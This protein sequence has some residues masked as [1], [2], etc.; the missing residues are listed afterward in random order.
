MPRDRKF[1][2]TIDPWAWLALYYA[3]DTYAQVGQSAPY[4]SNDWFKVGVSSTGYE[5]LGYLRFWGL[6][7]D[8]QGAHVAIRQ[9]ELCMRVLP[10]QEANP[11]PITAVGVAAFDYATLMYQSGAPNNGLP[12]V[13]GRV[14]ATNGNMPGQAT[15]PGWAVSPSCGGYGWTS[16]DVSNATGVRQREGMDWVAI[17]LSGNN[18]SGAGTAK[19][20]ISVEGASPG[21]AYAGTGGAPVLMLNWKWSAYQTTL[22]SPADGEQVAT[23]TPTLQAMLPNPLEPAAGGGG[24]N[25][26]GPVQIMFQVGTSPDL[27]SGGQVWSSGWL[28]APAT[29]QAKSSTMP[30]NILENGGTYYWSA[31][32]FDGEIWSVASNARKFT[33]NLQLGG[34]GPSP[35]DS[36]G[37]ATV[38]LATGNLFV[39]TQTQSFPAVGGTVGATFSYNSLAP[40]DQGLKGEYFG[41]NN[42]TNLVAER[43]TPS[44]WF[45][46][47]TGPPFENGPI[48]GW[49]ARMVR[50]RPGV[51]H[52]WR[53][54]LHHLDLPRRCHQHLRG[55][56]LV[57]DLLPVQLGLLR[58]VQAV[59]AGVVDAGLLAQDHRRFREPQHGIR[60]GCPADQRH[61]GSERVDHV[62][63][64]PGRESVEEVRFA[65]ARSVGALRRHRWVAAL[66]SAGEL[67]QHGVA[68]PS[69]WRPGPVHLDGHGLSA[70]GIGIRRPLLRVCHSDPMRVDVEWERDLDL[71]HP[72]GRGRHVV[73]RGRRVPCGLAGLHVEH[74]T[75]PERDP[76]ALDHRP[77]V[78]QAGNLLVSRAIE[79]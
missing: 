24:A 40:S 45:N 12:L 3:A 70:R 67:E 41:Q 38:N 62:E 73:D 11:K 53:F 5:A 78:G 59:V 48:S 61:G 15:T 36:L 72:E 7:Q 20:F 26:P 22:V 66:R 74:A 77:G 42:Y 55:R 13:D 69:R 19:D 54:E 4:G 29:G 34:S 21:H 31:I 10:G 50:L 75:G 58:M 76:L 16:V 30:A 44:L 68:G 56:G 71:L 47:G 14:P 2:V 9:S 64:T 57:G 37:P 23:M 25:Y 32:V 46:W 35:Y 17:G 27:N 51:W 18:Q 63:P 79:R 39:K 33:V 28:S 60:V 49:S 1:P 65:A 52:R 6:P 8:A 43:R